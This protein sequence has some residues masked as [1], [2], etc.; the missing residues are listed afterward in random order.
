MKKLLLSN[1]VLATAALSRRSRS[2]KLQQ[3]QQH[4][5]F[6]RHLG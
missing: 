3:Q 6:A 4:A 2:V 5:A 1:E